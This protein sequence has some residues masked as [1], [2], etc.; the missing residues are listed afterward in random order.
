MKFGFSALLLLVGIAV[1]FFL[2]QSASSQNTEPLSQDSCERITDSCKDFENLK[3]RLADVSPEQIQEYLRTQSADE[4]LRKADK[5]LGKIV[6]A[7]VATVGFRLQKEDLDQFGRVDASLNERGVQPPAKNTAPLASPEPLKVDRALQNQKANAIIQ[8]VDTDEDA[9]KLLASLGTDYS[10]R[11][12]A[13][14][15]LN[16]LQ[17]RELNGQFDGQIIYLK[18]QKNHRVRLRFQGRLSGDQVTGQAAVEIF[19]DRGKRWSHGRSSGNLTKNFTA[20]GP[21]IFIESGGNYF[22]LVYFPRLG[23]WMGHFLESDKGTLKK[24]GDVVLRRTGGF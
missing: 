11:I 8:I 23:Q 22:E 15:G 7:L 3:T 6:S 13:S 2:G 5:I 14:K 18:D 17:L 10:N 12:Q 24:T 19:N 20:S 4:K 1:G 9:E 16:R 21:S